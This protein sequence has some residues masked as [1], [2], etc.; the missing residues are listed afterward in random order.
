MRWR[1]CWHSHY[2]LILFNKGK[3]KGRAEADDDAE[4]VDSMAMEID[5]PGS[6]FGSDTGRPSSGKKSGTS[7]EKKAAPSTVTRKKA[8]S[9]GRKGIVSRASH[10][11]SEV[12]LTQLEV[13]SDDDGDDDEEEIDNDELP[14]ST[15]RTKR[16]AAARFAFHTSRLLLAPL[17]YLIAI[18]KRARRPLPA[19]LQR[20]RNRQHWVLR[21]LA[22]L[23]GGHQ[24]GRQPEEREGRW[25]TL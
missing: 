5:E 21:P 12:R 24:P 10:S 11:A 18:R 2:V 17:N 3:A 9:S 8:S 19:N 6:D 25:L 16:G 20:K 23:L 1:P 4:S 7:R 14:K 13:E 22:P 15:T